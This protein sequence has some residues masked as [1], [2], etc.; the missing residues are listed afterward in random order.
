MI[1]A[2]LANKILSVGPEYVPPKG[3]IAQVVYNY[4]RDV[5]P[6]NGFRYI[7]NSCEGN[8]FKKICKLRLDRFVR[9]LKEEG[10]PD[11]SYQDS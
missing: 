2:E 6:N 10:V 11:T 5:F 7:S 4:S 3:G 1:S 9:K 8:R